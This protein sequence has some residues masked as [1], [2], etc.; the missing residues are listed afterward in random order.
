MKE[1][2]LILNLCVHKSDPIT[3]DLLH[4][5][6]LLQFKNPVSSFGASLHWD[7]TESI[8]Q[9]HPCPS[10]AVAA[11]QRLRLHV[12]LGHPDQ[13]GHAQ[14]EGNGPLPSVGHRD[15]R[16]QAHGK[17][18]H[19]HFHPNILSKSS[20]VKRLKIEQNNTPYTPK[21]KRERERELDPINLPIK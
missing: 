8:F 2:A 5:L 18:L 16:D 12:G 3:Y 14:A 7:L 20:A 10:V 11:S 21:R 9:C 4:R 15:A 1:S 17:K 13:H 6:V 19:S